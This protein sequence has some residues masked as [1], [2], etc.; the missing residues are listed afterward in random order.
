MCWFPAYILL[1]EREKTVRKGTGLGFPLETIVGV[2]ITLV[3]VIT[4]CTTPAHADSTQRYGY[5]WGASNTT[6]QA[7][8]CETVR[9]VDQEY[10]SVRLNERIYVQSMDN[11]RPSHFPGDPTPSEFPSATWAYPDLRTGAVLLSLSR[12]ATGTLVPAQIERQPLI[13]HYGVVAYGNVQN[14]L[15]KSSWFNVTPEGDTLRVQLDANQ[16][17]RQV[18]VVIP[19]G[20]TVQLDVSQ[21]EPGIGVRPMQITIWHEPGGWVWTNGTP[22][23]EEYPTLWGT[24]NRNLVKVAFQDAAAHISQ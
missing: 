5:G 3:V 11:G 13:R 9:C 19:K 12:P 10:V 20:R 16:M 21:F 17:G 6:F 14:D 4:S 24:F 1:F 7:F 22:R 2:I 15:R 18:D 8:Q 23:F